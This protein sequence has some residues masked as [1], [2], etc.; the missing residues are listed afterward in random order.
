MH[1]FAAYYVKGIA[2]LKLVLLGIP[3][4]VERHLQA[5]L[6]LLLGMGGSREHALRYLARRP[7]RNAL[8][9]AI[10]LALKRLNAFF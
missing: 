9:L 7:L 10:G 8:E 1:P 3:R 2:S 6:W 5:E 4:G